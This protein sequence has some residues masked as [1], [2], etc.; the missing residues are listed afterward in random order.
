MARKTLTPAK[1]E[2]TPV[3]T[4]GVRKSAQAAN[5]ETALAH[6]MADSHVAWLFM[7][8]RGEIEAPSAVQSLALKTIN[9][10]VLGVEEDKH[11]KSNDKVT[12]NITG[13]GIEPTG[14]TI[15]GQ[16]EEV[17]DE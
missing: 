4:A 11:K 12:I 10:L 16:A 5:R 17:G 6:P 7:V 14:V 3:T 1:I 2:K 13:I 15:D 9:E 8:A